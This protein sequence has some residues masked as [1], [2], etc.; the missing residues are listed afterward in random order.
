MCNFCDHQISH[1]A[2]IFA[3]VK[4]VTHANEHPSV[5][6]CACTHVCPFR[7]YI[8]KLYIGVLCC[9]LIVTKTITGDVL[10]TY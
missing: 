8:V 3:I 5:C 7:S 1:L 4:F 9:I 6:V 2:V 10:T